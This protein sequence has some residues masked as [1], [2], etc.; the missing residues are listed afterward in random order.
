MYICKYKSEIDE[1]N[2][3]YANGKIYKNKDYGALKSKINTYLLNVIH[4]ISG[5]LKSRL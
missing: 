3:I 5:S 2:N 4:K 1:F